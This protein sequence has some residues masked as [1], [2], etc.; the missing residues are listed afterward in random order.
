MSIFFDRKTYKKC[1][2]MEEM[3]NIAS[4]H[5]R[6]MEMYLRLRKL[7]TPMSSQ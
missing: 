4:T 6:L 5:L 3:P 7:G 1:K 2:G